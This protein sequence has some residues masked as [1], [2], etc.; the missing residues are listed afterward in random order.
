VRRLRHP[1]HRPPCAPFPKLARKKFTYRSV[2]P[3]GAAAA[4]VSCSAALS[5]GPFKSCKAEPDSVRSVAQAIEGAEVT[6]G[7]R[8]STDDEG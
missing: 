4:R 1:A 5:V 3:S 7:A 2:G 6:V 8:G